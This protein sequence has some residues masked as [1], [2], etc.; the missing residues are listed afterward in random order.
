MEDRIVSLLCRQVNK[1]ILLI[2]NMEC[3]GYIIGSSQK[4]IMKIII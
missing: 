3:F 2:L 4:I 1:I